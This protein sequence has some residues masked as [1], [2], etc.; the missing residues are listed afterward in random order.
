MPGG[1]SQLALDMRVEHAP[2]LGDEMRLAQVVTNLVENAGRYTPPGGRIG[3]RVG[4][5]GDAVVLEVSD[6]GAGIEPALLPH[7]FD[8]F[9][10]G[11][12]AVD[13]APGGLGIGLP[14]V[15]RLVEL[16]G[17]TVTARSDGPGHGATFEVRLPRSAGHVAAAETPPHAASTPLRIL[18]VDDHADA[19]ESLRTLLEQDGHRVD[20]AADGPAGVARIRAERPD[21]AIVDLAL[22]RFDARALRHSLQDDD[23]DGVPTLVALTGYGGSDNRADARAAGFD[24]AF[25]K[26]LDMAAFRA[27]LAG[28]RVAPV[29]D[30]VLDDQGR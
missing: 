17:G 2:V 6:T 21:V 12:H 25:A 20:V 3:V 7:V 10:Q 18:V 4:V 24:H 27:W 5:Q 15:R 30:A 14:A 22:R 8:L 16:H 9:V 26:P 29:A 1:S 11:E 23:A 13:R 28:G 19:R